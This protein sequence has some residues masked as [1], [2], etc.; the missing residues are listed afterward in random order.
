MSERGHKGWH[1]RG[2][3]PHFDQPDRVQH[4]VFRLYGSLLRD[5]VDDLDDIAPDVRRAA[6]DD[7]LDRGL[8]SRLLADPAAAAIVDGALRHFDGQRYRLLAWCVMSNH[9]HVVVEQ[10]EGWPLGRLVAAWKTYTAHEINRALGR[11]GRVW[12]KDYFDRYVRSGEGLASV[13][14]YVEANPVAAGLCA[15]AEDWPW[16]SAGRRARVAEARLFGVGGES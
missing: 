13:I 8:G 4:V 5:V 6:I 16:S 9:V 15:V 1:D 3:L 11:T 10:V 12:A 2:Y 7:Y 14:E